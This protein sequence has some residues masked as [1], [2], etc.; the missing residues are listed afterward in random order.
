MKLISDKYSID[1][2]EMALDR[3]ALA[4][5]HSKNGT[6]YIVLYEWLEKQLEARRQRQST[7]DSVM[8]RAARRRAA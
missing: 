6:I 4:I 8:A 7:M 3:V 2:I 1:D 5:T